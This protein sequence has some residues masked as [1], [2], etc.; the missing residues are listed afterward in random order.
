MPPPLYCVSDGTVPATTTGLLAAACAARGVAFVPIDAGRFDPCEEVALA[1][2]DL[3]FRPAVSY[4]AVR[5]EQALYDDSLATFYGDGE[6]LFFDGVAAPL[7]FAR[8]GLPIPRT[9]ALLHN[10]RAQLRRAVERVGGLPVVV[11]VPGGEGG[12]GVMLLESFASLASVLD[13]LFA[14]GRTPQLM[15]YVRGAT[16][17]RVVVVGSRAVAAYRNHPYPDDFRSGPSSDPLD[18]MVPT[19]SPLTELAVAAT[20]AIRREHAGV[21]ILQHES[22]RLYLLEANFPCYF[23]QAQLVGGIDVAGALLDHLLA[24]SERLLAE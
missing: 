21:D 19:P 22:G 9:I 20:R 11:K 17:W 7:L 1:A 16:H 14:A 18:Y 15:A 13:H 8:R 6:A 24:K 12:V 23:P 10:D 2:G 3:L 5:V 4:A